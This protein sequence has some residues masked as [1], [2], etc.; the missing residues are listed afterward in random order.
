[1]KPQTK[2]VLKLMGYVSDGLDDLTKQYSKEFPRCNVFKSKI[3]KDLKTIRKYMIALDGE[4]ERFDMDK[5][6]KQRQEELK[7]KQRSMDKR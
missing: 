4:L 3:N 5:L 7:L 6:R 2:T 1:M